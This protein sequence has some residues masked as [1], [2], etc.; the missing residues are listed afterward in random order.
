MSMLLGKKIGMT[1]IFDD[2]GN[3]QPVTVIQAGPCSVMC[4]KDIET[5]GNE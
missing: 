2:A 1:Q 4:V 3:L 5:D